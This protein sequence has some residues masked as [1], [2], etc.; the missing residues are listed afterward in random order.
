METRTLSIPNKELLGEVKRTIAEG[1]RAKIRVKG[2]SMRLFL[3]SERDLVTL[4][5]VEAEEIKLRDVVLAEIAPD[6]YV[7]HRVI[8]MSGQH[9][10][11]MGDGNVKGTEH[12]LRQHIVAR[13]S[14]FYRKGRSKPDLT[15]GKKWRI[16]SSLWLALK[17]LRRI[18]LGIY[19]RQ[20]FRI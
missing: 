12:C 4:V 3:E 10:T 19:R 8:A 15:T 13:V 1:R 11:L 14:E 7:L 2:N 6:H 9:I 20:P 16:Y 17:P 18:I 5:P